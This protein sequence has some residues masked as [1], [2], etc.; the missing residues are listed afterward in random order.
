MHDEGE[1]AAARECTVALASGSTSL[2]MVPNTQVLITRDKETQRI[3]PI[4]ELVRMGIRINWDQERI[5]M[6]RADGK[7]I[8]VWLDEGCPVVDDPVGVELMKEIEK[9]NKKAAGMMTV[10]I[11]GKTERGVRLCG[12]E[13]A[14]TAFEIAKLFPHVPPRL[15]ARIPGVDKEELDMSKVPFRPQQEYSICSV[16]NI[17]ERGW[18]WLMMD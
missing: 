2:R 11:D 13:A 14:N 16:V 7:K 18:K 6:T 3:I 12:E 4:R 9:M 1:W 8:P 17:L 5:T 15:A 10:F